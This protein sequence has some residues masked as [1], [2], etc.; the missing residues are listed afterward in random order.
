MEV[1]VEA[2]EGEGDEVD[3]T[4]VDD[5]MHIEQLWAYV[6][7]EQE[8]LWWWGWLGWGWLGCS[9]VNVEDED[10]IFSTIK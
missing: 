3:G 9:L 7:D 2:Y 6:E 1:D 4:K 10:R 8:M 5:D